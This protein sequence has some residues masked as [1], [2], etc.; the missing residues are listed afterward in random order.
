MPNIIQLHEAKKFLSPTYN[1]IIRKFQSS[2]PTIMETSVAT[3]DG[4][5]K[6]FGS[7][8]ITTPSEDVTVSYDAYGVSQ[9]C[10]N[11][12]LPKNWYCISN[13]T[14]CYLSP[15]VSFDK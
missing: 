11:S 6:Y 7:G 2:T 5:E 4:I 3:V 15:N 8:H 9:S 1:F 10:Y 14:K 13:T 12:S